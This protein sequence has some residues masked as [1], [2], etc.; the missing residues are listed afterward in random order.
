LL[1]IL[2]CS[3]GVVGVEVLKAAENVVEVLH[4]VSRYVAEGVDYVYILQYT[5]V[6]PV[7]ATLWV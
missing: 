5:G 2:Y 1:W 7:V 4:I 3:V 6:I